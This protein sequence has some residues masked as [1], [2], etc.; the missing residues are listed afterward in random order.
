M[1]GTKSFKKKKQTNLLVQYQEIIVFYSEN[2]TKTQRLYV[3]KIRSFLMLMHAV[4]TATNMTPRRN[5]KA[6]GNVFF[7][8]YLCYCKYTELMNGYSSKFVVYNLCFIFRT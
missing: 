4:H 5:S 2:H 1:K 8:S 7:S 6:V 3:A